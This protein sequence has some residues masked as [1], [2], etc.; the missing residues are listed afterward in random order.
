LLVVGDGLVIVGDA[1][2]HTRGVAGKP[3]IAETISTRD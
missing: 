1:N 3:E 2:K